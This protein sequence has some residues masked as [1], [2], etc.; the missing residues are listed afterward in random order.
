MALGGYKFAGYKYTRPADYD[1]SVDAQVL[2]EVLKMHKCKLKAFTE[3]CAAS[4]AQWDFSYSN[5]DYAFGTHGNVIY[6]LDS[7]GFN[8]VSFFRYGTDDAY[9]AIV[10]LSDAAASSG[11]ALTLS[12]YYHYYSG[13]SLYHTVITNDMSCVGLIDLN[14]NNI[15]TQPV[16][17]R[18]A[19]I[20]DSPAGGEQVVS[21]SWS[22][23]DKAYSIPSARYYG[24]L[25]KGKCI[26]SAINDNISSE[27]VFK[28]SAID[29]LNLSSPTDTKNIFAWVFT[30]IKYTG[31]TPATATTF[32]GT[33]Q[34]LRHNG[35]PYEK[36]SSYNTA[37]NTQ[38]FIPPAK[39]AV[40]YNSTS[41]IP[42]ESAVLFANNT[43]LPTGAP[44]N[45]DGILTKGTAMID[46]LAVNLVYPY[47]G[48][49]T[50]S[51]YANGNYLNVYD[52]IYTSQNIVS[53]LLNRFVYIGWDPSNPDITSEDA[54]TAYDG[55]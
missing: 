9:Y 35:D 22:S 38:L 33:I 16:Q 26:I 47:A 42:Y 10:T 44:L 51:T 19:L 31:G 27:R 48:I 52:F 8:L 15:N 49:N 36:V 43:S 24:Y 6:K 37:Y 30:S 29:C 32:R 41:N 2:A 1:S 3:S 54:W 28:L 40:S 7:S 50:N 53:Y 34:T 14:I 45:A 13:T 23:L 4:G 39:K 55:T 21:T 20:A 17:D 46:M 11:N 18:L 12:N 5:G 25:T